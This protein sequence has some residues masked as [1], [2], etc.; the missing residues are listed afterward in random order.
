MEKLL[1]KKERLS[2]VYRSEFQVP[3]TLKITFGINEGY[4]PYSLSRVFVATNINDDSHKLANS[5]IHGIITTAVGNWLLIT[6]IE[7]YRM[8][9]TRTSTT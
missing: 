6:Q 9:R 7:V 8:S 5:L 4:P 2:S 3:E 1:Q